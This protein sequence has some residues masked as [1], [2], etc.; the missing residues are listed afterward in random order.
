MTVFFNRRNINTLMLI[1][2]HFDVLALFQPGTPEVKH[3]DSYSLKEFVFMLKLSQNRKFL[4]KNGRNSG[5]HGLFAASSNS[6][7][8]W[9]AGKA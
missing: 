3:S 5:F 8:T 2:H 6:L 1:H 9:T 4:S 7:L